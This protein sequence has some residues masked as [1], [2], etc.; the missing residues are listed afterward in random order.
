LMM[1]EKVDSDKMYTVME[2]SIKWLKY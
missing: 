1:F 2:L